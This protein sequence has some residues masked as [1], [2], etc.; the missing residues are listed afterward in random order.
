MMETLV[1]KRFRFFFSHLLE[2]WLKR[3][4]RGEEGN[5]KYL[6]NGK[7]F[8]DKKNYLENEKS[9]L[10]QTR[11]VFHNSLRAFIGQKRKVAKISF[12]YSTRGS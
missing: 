1:V 9:I 2:Q 8:L 6:E 10:D 3:G 11:S 5:K 12:R 4:K 7:S